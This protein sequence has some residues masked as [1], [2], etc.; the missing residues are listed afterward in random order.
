MFQR[1]AA[2]FLCIWSTVMNWMFVRPPIC[3]IIYAPQ[4]ER[5]RFD[6]YMPWVKGEVDVILCIHGGAWVSGD[7]EGYRGIAEGYARK[8]YAV[9]ALNYRFIDADLPPEQQPASWEDMLDDIGAAIEAMKYKLL[10]EGY[11]PRR[12]A[13]TGDSAGGHLTMLYA[14]SRGAQCPLPIA[15][16]FPNVGPVDFTDPELQNVPL[17]PSVIE[18]AQ[19]LDNSSTSDLRGP[20]P[21]FYITPDAP[22]TLARYGAK[23][24]LV[25]GNTQGALLR[26]ALET[27]GV[28]C[29]VFVY[30]E[31]GHALENI[32]KDMI[33]ET[34]KKLKEYFDTYLSK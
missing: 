6:L 1:I 15:F 34:D 23:D 2:F 7:K 25:P 33:R 10:D 5:Q 20:S 18:L 29:D 4:T 32:P 13:I 28:R 26:N 30:P 14:Y 31:S 19:R 3:D 22:P 8:G 16:I 24:E 27:A 12:L 17:G 9:A 21:V 11:T